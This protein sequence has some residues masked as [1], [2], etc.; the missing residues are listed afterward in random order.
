M[1]LLIAYD[2]SEAANGIFQDLRR[3]GLPRVA[4]VRVVTVGELWLPPPAQ[5]LDD[6]EMIERYPSDLEGARLLATR[7]CEMVRAISPA[8]DVAPEAFIG[9]S[10]LEILMFADRWQPDLIV[11]GSHGLSTLG[12]L[13]FG[14]TSQKIV[15]EA[16]CSVRVARAH[17]S[18]LDNSQPVRII[19]GYDGSEGSSDVINTIAGRQW[20]KGSEVQ[21]ITCI[22][23]AAP[24]LRKQAMA[25]GRYTDPH[26]LDYM[27]E[28]RSTLSRAHEAELR[29]LGLRVSAKVIEGDPKR[30]LVEEA[31]RFDADTVFVGARSLGRIE[32]FVLGS[33]SSAVASRATCSVEVVRA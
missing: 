27:Q 32:R 6:T 31:Q 3:A 19:V 24:V 29:A 10:A 12:R 25:V 14:S 18:V 17:E 23:A 33:I 8:W 26:R 9:S 13:I 16:R 7:G 21:L 4:E 1:R 30:A 15:A 22:G 11:A 2:G 28:I 5:I 20:P